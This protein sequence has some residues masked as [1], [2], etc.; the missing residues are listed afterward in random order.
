MNV[1]DRFNVVSLFSGIGGLDYG[2]RRAIPNA[3]T[4]LYVEREAFACAVLLKT[5]QE[6]ALDLAPIWTDVSTLDGRPWRGVVD[7]IAG[8]FPCQDISNAGK[9]AGIY[10]ERSGLWSQYARIISEIQPR[11]V[12]IENVAALRTRGLDRVLSDLAALGFDAEWG[13]VR[14]SDAGAPHKRDR[15]FL[16]A[17]AVSSNVR[18]ESGW[19]GGA[20]GQGAA[21]PDDTREVVAHT[22]DDDGQQ[23]IWCGG[24]LDDE[25]TS[26]GGDV[27]G[28]CREDVGNSDR[29]VLERRFEPIIRCADERTT[30]PPGPED[31][32]GWRQWKGTQPAVCRNADGTRYRVD[33][34]RALGNAVVPQQAELAIRSLLRRVGK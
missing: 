8:G 30:W 23:G 21:E 13:C 32:E 11:Y 10:G 2:I 5:M 34:L 4:V 28:P 18:D 24:L 26:C 14:A 27:D 3:R 31:D 19:R 15:L 17:Y 20:Y 29:A 6:G 12:L 33:R 7:C 16:L 1:G 22:D 9:R 25:R